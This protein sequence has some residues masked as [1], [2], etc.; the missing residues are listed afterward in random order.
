M[1]IC[2]QIWCSFL[3]IFSVPSYYYFTNFFFFFKFGDAPDCNSPITV[4]LSFQTVRN[5]AFE[6]VLEKRKNAGNQH[7]YLL[8]LEMFS[9]L[10]NH[11]V[12][13]CFQPGQTCFFCHAWIYQGH[14]VFAL[15][16][17]LNIGQLF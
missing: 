1:N 9:T 14:I 11:N 8:F 5:K 15:S 2:V 10:F 12:C 4:I 3:F 16:I 6:N 17:C 13:Q 7:K